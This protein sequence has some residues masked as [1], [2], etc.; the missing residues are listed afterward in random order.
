MVYRAAGAGVFTTTVTNTSADCRER[1]LAFDEFQ[2]LGVLAFCGFLEVALHG[3]MRR[4]GGLAG[5]STRRITVDAVTV[6]VVFVPLV[7][8]PFH[9]IRQ[10]LFGIGLRPVF[11]AE[12]LSE[13]HGSG[14]AVLDAAA[15]GHAVLRVYFGHIGTAAHVGRIEQLRRTQRVANLH[16]AVADGK[17][18]A[19]AVDVRHL[20]HE[21][22]VFSFAEDSHR[23]VVGDVVSA[24]RLAQVIC[25]I[26]HTDAPITV[27]VGAAFVQF[28]AAIAAT[29]D[30]H[31]DVSLVFLEPIADMFDINGL[32][33]HGDGFLHGNDMH[34]DARTA[35]GD[36]RRDLLEREEGHALEEHRELGMT[37]HEFG[38]HVRIFGAARHKHR[39]PV[40]AVLAV[41]GGAGVGSLPVGIVVAV[42]VFQ[43]AEIGKA[44]QQFVE[45]LVIGRIVF[46]SIPRMQLGVGVVLAHFE[47]I[48][49]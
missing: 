40:D 34:A 38:V 18:L 10:L 21:T 11:G 14:G 31:A 23:L 15:A 2:R 4:T 6:S 9:S 41:E 44:V 35:H 24:A 1:V 16:V 49:G 22:V 30:T 27:V 45:A 47:E 20:M 26:A 48:A 19:L 5:C 42:V 37:V 13:F 7:L 36:E 43:H 29:A 46:L 25:H 12:F 32:V 3:N 17:D 39:H 28:L 33:L 8:A